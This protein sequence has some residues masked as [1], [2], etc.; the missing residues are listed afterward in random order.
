M[1]TFSKTEVNFYKVL[2]LPRGASDS[3]IKKSYRKLAK[4]YHPDAN[5]NKDTTEQFQTL[6][7]AYEVLSDPGL[8]KNYDMFGGRGIGTS[9]AS[10][11]EVGERVK[12]RE[13]H[14]SAD[15]S[16]FYEN[17]HDDF[18]QN[19]RRNRSRRYSSGPVDFDTFSGRWENPSD[20]SS[21]WEENRSKGDG[22]SSQWARDRDEEEDEEFDYDA[23]F[24]AR[25][26][27]RA[28][29]KAYG[30]IIGE[31]IAMHY[32]IDFKTAVLGGQIEVPINRIEECGACSGT[33]TTDESTITACS[34]CGGS[35]VTIPISKSGP[36]FSIACPDCS[37]TGKQIN[38]P[39]NV[40][41]GSAVVQKTTTVK[42]DI[43]AG[44]MD[45]NKM[46]IR[47]EGDS[48]P[49]AGPSGDLFIFIKVKEDPIFKREGSDI[50]ADLMISCKD[51]ILGTTMKVP[52]I[53][54]EETIEIPPGSQPGDVICITNCGAP[55]L[56]ANQRGDH[57]VKIDVEI[58]HGEEDNSDPLVE[59]LKKQNDSTNSNIAPP[60]Q[61]VRSPHNF[62]VPFST[63]SPDSNSTE[64]ATQTIT[65]ASVPFP[66]TSSA[67]EVPKKKE[68]STMIDSET[69]NELRRK[70]REVD[71]E[72]ETRIKFEELANS[73]E[74]ELKEHM[75]R[76]ERLQDEIESERKQR[77]H[78]EHLAAQRE[79]ELEES[80]RRQTAM[81]EDIAIRVRQPRGQMSRVTIK[82]S[83]EMSR[84]FEMIA[85][86]KGLRPSHLIFTLNGEELLPDDTPLDLN[87]EH[88]CIIDVIVP[89]RGGNM[90]Q[91]VRLM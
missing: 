41:N 87:L 63:S 16:D 67:E 29:P 44:V 19:A 5:P 85:R 83:T 10:D 13:S 89:S 24:G 69:L 37:G 56:I 28:R 84:V 18:F 43:P 82:K 46:R 35:G 68:S 2:G 7:R 64:Q 88:D 54:G 26:R 55:S 12:R 76:L 70:A 78:F 91:A 38:N 4:L 73:R 14:W 79:A 50:L 75:V 6:N 71:R 45:G 31:D 72:R 52:T 57:F 39:C 8:R 30:P 47:G 21:K 25:K 1:S 49:N 40:C 90:G 77:E 53:D 86:H 66:H 17:D 74:E 3:E 9:A 15:M 42:I 33:G 27:E 32:E 11:V 81:N 36:V 60:G 58:P 61:D 48:G 51:A 34:T 65:N 22:F 62:S 23:W 20:D 59:M 80:Y